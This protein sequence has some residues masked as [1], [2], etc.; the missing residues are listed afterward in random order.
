MSNPALFAPAF[1][2][3]MVLRLVRLFL[4]GTDGDEQRA[5]QA[6]HAALLALHPR[7]EAELLLAAE[8]ISFSL[9]ALDALTR[10]LE[11]D[12]S[13]NQLCRLRSNA[14]S[15]SREAHKA[16]RRLE[17]LQRTSPPETESAVQPEAVAAPSEV[18]RAPSVT[19]S[20]R[21]ERPPGQTWTQNYHQRQREKRLAE[22]ERKRELRDGPPAG[23]PPASGDIPVQ[24]AS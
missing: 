12:L 18:A 17:Q 4:T 13:V 22:R 19:P 1:L 20:A 11:P 23:M 21:G 5:R 14:V 24:P 15:M 2:E 8:V 10:S 7:S 16:Q 6:A 3:V 9:H